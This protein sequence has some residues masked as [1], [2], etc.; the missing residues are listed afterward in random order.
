MKIVLTGGA[1]GGHF[2]PLVAVAEALRDLSH[3][4]RILEPTLYF[5]S[6]NPYDQEALFENKIIFVQCSAGKVRRYF[7]FLNLLDVFKTLWGTL[8]ACITLFQIYPDVVISKGGYTSVPVTIAANIL[9]IPVIIHESDAKPGRANLFASK[10]AYRI[11]ISYESSRSYF[12]KKVQDR[13]ALTGIPIRKE[14]V[15]AGATTGGA[16]EFVLDSTVPTILILGG[17]SGSKTINEV[18]LLAL[19]ELTDVANVIHQTG[20]V[21]FEEVRSLSTLVL[22]KAQ[23]PSRYH[24]FPY[25]NMLTMRKAA[26]VAT[27][28]I[29][30]AGSTAIA[31]ISL[32]KKPAILIPIPESVS[33]DQRTNAYAFAHTGGATVLEE[34]NLTPHVL[35]S[36]VKR[37][38][39]DPAV[40]SHMA[41]MSTGFANPD[42]AR[43]LADEALSIGLSH[44]PEGHV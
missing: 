35:V 36:E 15:L 41:Q 13:I 23:H 21:N 32:W 37:I 9:R 25:L 40:A 1:T 19:P 29:S 44:E 4:R 10:R 38:A 43:I 24:V 26:G 2:Y 16:E 22:Q 18:V 20:K 28:V 30:R 27:V 11:A 33:H 34:A 31:E 17:S 39:L 6:P 12:P 8:S 42:S 7:S 3:E 14:L 5:M